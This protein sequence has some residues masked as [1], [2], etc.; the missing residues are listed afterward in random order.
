M[1]K[2]LIAGVIVSLAMTGLF[3]GVSFAADAAA[4]KVDVKAAPAAAKK[5]DVKPA[6]PAKAAKKSE[7]KKDSTK[8]GM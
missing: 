8:A 6:K 7:A 4:P 5:V 2:N 3:G 1:K